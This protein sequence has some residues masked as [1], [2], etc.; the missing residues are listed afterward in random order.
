M[1]LFAARVW[2]MGFERIPIATFAMKGH[3][4]RLLR[5]GQ[6]GDR[7]I[8]VG[9]QTDRTA[10]DHQGRILGMAEIGFEPLR[11]LDL[12]GRT[13]LDSR[14]FDAAG[15]FKFPH[16]VALTRAWRFEPAPLLIQT[17]SRQL[18]MIATSGVQ[19]IIDPSDVAAILDLNAQEIELP[20]LPALEGMRR[21]ND[22]LRN[23][24]GPRPNG[25]GYQVSPPSDG[26]AWTYVLRF[27]KR[28]VWKIG[29]RSMSMPAVSRSISTSRPNWGWSSGGSF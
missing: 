19:E 4:D 9:T 15:N 10:A 3:L 5:L 18:T 23:T 6:R 11:T 7:L 25:A 12:V 26:E 13:E 27:G 24:T 21:M 17:L 8:F 16:A 1:R 29:W 22:A 2:G 14:D 20:L 28:D